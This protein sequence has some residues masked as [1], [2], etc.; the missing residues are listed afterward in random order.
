MAPTDVARYL[1]E[2]HQVGEEAYQMFKKKRLEKA[3]LTMKFYDKILVAQSRQLHTRDVRTHP[4]PWA[5]A[6][7]YGSLR[8]TKAGLAR[9]LERNVSPSEDTPDPSTCTI[10]G[11]SLVQKMN[12][13]NKT[14]AHV[15]Q[16]VM[17]VVLHDGLQSHRIDVVSDVYR[18]TSIKMLRSATGDQAQL[19]STR[20]LQEA[21]KSRSGGSSCV[22][23][24]T[25]P[26]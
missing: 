19:S 17:S 15:A 9:Q 1:L 23:P 7:A 8:K 6:N 16:S 25:S 21:T 12:G 2:A 11:M 14:F 18:E 13:N 24:A 3:P 10:D 4:L 22:A 26:A 20:T 5:L